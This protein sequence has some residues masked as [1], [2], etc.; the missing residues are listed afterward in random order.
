MKSPL[1]HHPFTQLI[2]LVII[3]LFSLFVFSLIGLLLAMPLFGLSIQDIFQNINAAALDE[4]LLL[5][6]YLQ[7]FQTIGLFVAPPFLFAWLYGKDIFQYLSAR[8][9]P[10]LASMVFV[11]LILFIGIPFIGYLGKINQAVELPEFLKNAEQW[12]M[13]R[14]MKAEKLTE[15]FLRGKT[16]TD[17][18]LNVV[19]VAVLPAI[20][21]EFL[22][23]GVLQRLMLKW[24]KNA[25]WAVFI[26]AFAFSALHIQFYGF[27]P[28]FF[29][30][31]IFGYFLVWSGTIWLPVLAH[32]VNNGVA[33]VYYYYMQN[34]TDIDY[35]DFSGY[36][37]PML[38]VMFSLAGFLYFC[39]LLY[40]NER[41]LRGE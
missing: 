32:F 15:K 7:S 38:V 28:R 21:E 24:T 37:M 16:T 35:S 13:Q 6:K 25:H 41:K 19:L 22:F 5:F 36:D 29:L 27:L 33:V 20:G 10:D 39:Y 2:T 34:Q 3:M 23:R 1:N 14:E 4:N 11:V 17:L 8:K 30:G 12:L 31:L 26:A 40:S 18:V 9:N